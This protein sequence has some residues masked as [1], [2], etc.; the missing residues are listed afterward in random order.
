MKGIKND[1]VRGG[2]IILERAIRRGLVDKKTFVQRYEGQQAC[3]RLGDASFK[4]RKQ[5]VQRLCASFLRCT[6][7]NKKATLLSEGEMARGR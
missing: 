4:Q 3:K 6:Q 7:S 1:R 2:Q 5:L